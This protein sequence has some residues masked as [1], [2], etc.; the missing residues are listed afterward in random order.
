MSKYENQ[1]AEYEKALEQI[2]IDSER[3]M[4]AGCREFSARFPKRKMYILAGN[5]S[6]NLYV[7]GKIRGQKVVWD[8]NISSPDT[9]FGYGS[10]SRE[11]ESGK[12]YYFGRDL[13][14]EPPQQFLDVDEAEASFG[15]V[16]LT[17]C[18]RDK[19]FFGGEQF[20]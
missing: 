15:L 11:E 6:A 17:S 1:L 2:Y 16:S 12:I 13:R 19:R 8:F 18:L 3:H 14:I 10:H 7:E 9:L 20:G 5:G 4:Y